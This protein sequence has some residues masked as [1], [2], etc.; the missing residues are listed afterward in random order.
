MGPDL[1]WEKGAVPGKASEFTA[2]RSLSVMG[3]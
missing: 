2:K 1:T 3:S